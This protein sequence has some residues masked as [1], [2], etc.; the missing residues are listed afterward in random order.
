MLGPL[1]AFVIFSSLP[2]AF[3]VVFVAS[4]CVALIGLGVIVLLVQP[5]TATLSVDE[6]SVSLTAAVGLFRLPAFRRL[7]VAGAC[8]SLATVSDSFVFLTLQQQGSFSTAYFP[9]LYV[10]VAG[11]N[12]VLAVPIGRLADRRGRW[13]TFL[14]GHGMLLLVY[15]ALITPGAG[16][17]RLAVALIVFGAYYAATDGVLSA[18]A[19]ASLP[20]NLCGSGLAILVTI[21]NVARLLASILFGIL[22]QW[23]GLTTAIQ[24]FGVTLIIAIAAAAAARPPRSTALD[25]R[26]R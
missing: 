21:T 24:L 10:G 8:L 11:V 17:T 2:G 16:L 15:V 19:S 3:D 6:P 9:L 20:S 14:A 1:V 25:L 23:R 22:W 4:F 13:G 18:M 5:P 7:C 26:V 12:S